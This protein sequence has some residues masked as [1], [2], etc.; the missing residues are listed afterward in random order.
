M[1]S[2]KCHIVLDNGRLKTTFHD[3]HDEFTIK[4]VF[5]TQLLLFYGL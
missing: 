5:N 3:K 2:F 1:Q 4:R